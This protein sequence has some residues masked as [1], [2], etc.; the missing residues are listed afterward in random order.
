[1]SSAPTPPPPSPEEKKPV[2][3]DIERDRERDRLLTLANVHRMRGQLADA[4]ETLKKAIALSEAQSAGDAP[5][6][7]MLGDIL[8]ADEKWDDAKD[9]YNTAH[10]LDPARAS[11]ERKFA[12]MTLRAADAKAERALLDA[13]LRGELPPAGAAPI[14]GKRASSLA[15]LL[16]ALMPGAGQLYNGQTVKGLICLGIYALS[17]IVVF[18]S[19]GGSEFLEGIVL[20]AVP[21]KGRLPSEPSPL[22][23]TFFLAGVVI[24]IYAVLD[25]PMIANKINQGTATPGGSGGSKP[26]KTGWEV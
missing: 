8:A 14:H 21:M 3:S 1:M 6:H 18:F 22:L 4:R 2:L 11:A 12:Q 24:W 13:Q 20:F 5:I 17:L 9:A 25:A 23:L 26:D 15:F 10:V 19:P 16:S 7:E